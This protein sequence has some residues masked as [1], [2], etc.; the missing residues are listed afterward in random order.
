GLVE[1]RMGQRFAL[2][3]AGE[4]PRDPY[5]AVVDVHPLL[6]PRHGAGQRI[7]ELIRP[8]D[9]AR[10]QVNPGAVRQRPALYGGAELG[11]AEFAQGAKQRGLDDERHTMK[12]SSATNARSRRERDGTL[13]F[14]G[15]AKSACG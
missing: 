5:G 10:P 13:D 7:E 4:K 2:R 8:G 3:V 1:H 14:Y 11:N 12:S 6:V 15:S 9:E